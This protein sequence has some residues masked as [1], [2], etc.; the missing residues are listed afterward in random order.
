[1]G[2]EIDEGIG[3]ALA[4]G[5]QRAQFADE[6]ESDWTRLEPFFELDFAT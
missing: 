1:V 2:Q 3:A 6:L 5:V 4:L